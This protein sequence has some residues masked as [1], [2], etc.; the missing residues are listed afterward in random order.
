MTRSMVLKQKLLD[1]QIESSFHNIDEQ[2]TE[3][4]NSALEIK[5]FI[6]T[7]KAQLEKLNLPIPQLPNLDVDSGPISSRTRYQIALAKKQLEEKQSIQQQQLAQAHPLQESL[8]TAP[9]LQQSSRKRGRGR[10][11]TKK[12]I[13]NKYK[14]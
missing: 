3:L 14:L 1:Q 10:G 8:F 13:K 11:G 9:Q 4:K 5:T 12:T 2:I 6:E 7:N